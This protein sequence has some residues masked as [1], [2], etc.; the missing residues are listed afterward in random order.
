MD[1]LE[2]SEFD[3]KDC[4][5]AFSAAA[6][7]D[8]WGLLL[9]RDLFF[10]FSRFEQFQTRLSVSKSVLSTKLKGLL[11]KD[12]VKLH[13]YKVKGQRTRNEYR[14]T[15]KGFQ[16]AYLMAAMI[17]WG[18]EQMED[19]RSDFLQICNLEGEPVKLIFSDASGRALRMDEIQVNFF[20][21]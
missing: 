1:I 10:G 3:L 9:V 11:E 2:K 6:I 20:R 15:R 17:E 14:L 5:V 8:K 12:I 19:S 4:P 13:S 18:N 7:G 16:L 21:E